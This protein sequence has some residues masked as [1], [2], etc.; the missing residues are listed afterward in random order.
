MRIN[1]YFLIGFVAL[2]AVALP[3]NAQFSNALLQDAYWDQGKAE[4]NIY[5]AMEV[6]YGIP[7]ATEVRHILVKEPWDATR[8]V[9]AAGKGDFPVI[10]LN[11]VIVVPTGVYT[12]Y[13]MHSTFVDPR[14][15]LPVKFSMGSHEACG[16][17]FKSGIVSKDQVRLHEFSYFDGEGERLSEVPLPNAPWILYDELPIRLRL[18][19]ASPLTAP[20]AL[21]ILPSTVSPRLGKAE[22]VAGT[23]S[24]ISR[25]EKEVTYRLEMSGK[26]DLLTFA[27]A[28]PYTLLRWKRA[29]GSNLILKKSVLSDYW[30]RNKPGDEL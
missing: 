27:A 9:K 12:Y 13:Q 29:D 17:T 19:A 24:E 22:F 30:N 3:A 5:T 16:N 6:R 26:E 28:H 7:R 8:H 4:I 15:G 14:T 1:I 25:N 23:L 10:K 18:L 21:Q 20:I 11:Q 2:T